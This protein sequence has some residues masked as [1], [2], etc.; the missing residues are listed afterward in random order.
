MDSRLPDQPERREVL[1]GR[2]RELDWFTAALN[3]V[4]AGRGRVAMVSGEAGIGKT[5][6]VE[7][8][9]GRALAAGA[10]VW[11]GRC[12]E[13]GGAP[14]YWPWIQILREAFRGGDGGDGAREL[15]AAT[16]RIGQALPELRA[17]T[18]AHRVA[19]RGDSI[20]PA[21]GSVSEADLLHALDAPNVGIDLARFRLF[22][23]VS[24][25]LRH[26]AAQV[27][28]MIALDDLHAA[29]IDSLLLLK[30]VARDLLQ[31]HILLAGTYRDADLSQSLQ[32]ATILGEVAREGWNIRLRGLTE[33][34]AADLVRRHAGV[35]ADEELIASLHGTSGGNP[36]FL[37][38]I[39][40][41]MVVEG[42]FG[43]G[44]RRASRFTI[45]DTV[46]S[47]VRRNLAAIP[48]HG[49]RALAAA[50]V[51]GQEFDLATLA[52]VL[53]VP[54]HRAIESLES[55]RARGII[56]EKPG[57]VGHFHFTHAI[58]PEALRSGLGFTES[59]RLHLGVAEAVERINR[60]DP[61]PHYAEL[62][63]HFGHAVALGAADKAAEYARLGAERARNQFAYDEAAR[64]N[65]LALRAH[66]ARANPAPAERCELL[67]ALGDA[68]SKAG[69]PADAKHAF[70]EAANIA[71]ELKRND[72][73]ARAAIEASAGLGTFFGVDQE[74]VALLEEAVGAIG[75]TDPALLATLLARLAHELEWSDRRGYAT[76]LCARA[77][78]LARSANNPRALISALWS[79]HVLNWGP[80]NVE[81]RLAIAKEI[82]G[83]AAPNG[84]L[85]WTLRAHEI[86]LS[87][88]LELGDTVAADADLDAAQHFKAVLGYGFFTVE[89]FRPTRL[90]MRGEFGHAETLIRDMLRQA[91]RRQDAALITTFGAQLLMLHTEQGRVEEIEGELRA[92]VA[93]FPAMVVAR[94]GLAVLHA[95][96]GRESEAHA[97][98]DYLAQRGFARIASDFNW[99][100]SFCAC[101]EIAAVVGDAERC[102]MLYELLSKFP[103]RNVTIGWGDICYGAVSRYLGQLATVLGRF[104]EGE[105]HFQDAIGFERAMGAPPFVARTL[106][107]YAA[108]LL[109][110]AQGSDREHAR[111]IL[112]EALDIA[113]MIGMNA[114]ARRVRAMATGLAPDAARAGAQPGRSTARIGETQERRLATIMFLDIVD[115]TGR[116]VLLGDRGWSAVLDDY[117]ALVRRELRKFGGREV[118]TFGDDFLALFDAPTQ[119]VRCACAIRDAARAAGIEVRAGLH[120]GECQV[121]GDDVAGIAVHIGA[122][123]IR[124]AEPGAVLVSSTVKDLVTG[125]AFEF[126][127]RGLHALRGV[128]GE[129]RVF[130]A[131]E[132]AK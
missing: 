45:P 96:T 104:A 64:L 116:A 115:S 48:D 23:S 108:L 82:A 70:L 10:R 69:S 128:P 105:K 13:G 91:Q 110:R 85:G 111:Q 84:Y 1:V 93:R 25:L 120:S 9:A 109:A 46:R 12:W 80:A 55:A 39:L 8:A 74:L 65:Q 114:L 31:S 113:T 126:A 132:P 14:A 56:D 43:R 3:D 58:I 54:G 35:V 52:E 32:H 66:A 79:S 17:I 40:R 112:D 2:E 5:R 16:E 15:S 24:S 42:G 22:D 89:R 98:L 62:A 86:R 18:S 63:N 76:T 124:L 117:Y 60:G 130:A 34:A 26:V 75:D 123:V 27:P 7:E 53:G 92:S 99:L 103:K 50:S 67:L 81:Q 127:D 121:S 72:L 71:R 107:G 21:P 51:I 94:I 78:D 68:Q 41:V 131:G 4:L 88:L 33:S 28:L 47:A 125:T 102:G 36:F 61:A 44:T 83:L 11:W 6:L 29:D 49:Q 95:R 19:E 57:S 100:Y 77:I 90:L 59:M 101:A 87:A 122:R 129:W 30:F 118:N 119:A 106:V 73:L 97:E 20:F 37:H 38:E